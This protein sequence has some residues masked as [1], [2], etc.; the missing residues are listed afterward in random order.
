MVTVD[1][2]GKGLLNIEVLWQQVWEAAH[3]TPKPL[4][5]FVAQADVMVPEQLFVSSQGRQIA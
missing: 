1:D 2:L 5:R 3:E 4:I